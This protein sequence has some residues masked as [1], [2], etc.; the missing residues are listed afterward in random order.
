MPL[1]R[2]AFF[3]GQTT[4][5]L[6]SYIEPAN[7]P[8]AT[9]K[10]H[11]PAEEGS[12]TNVRGWHCK[13]YRFEL[14]PQCEPILMNK[15][16]LSL[17]LITAALSTTSHAEGLYGSIKILS[18]QQDLSDALLTSPRVNNR[19]VSPTSSKDVGGSVAVGYGF[20]GNWRL[21]TEYSL[22]QNSEFKSHWAPFDANVNNMQVSSSRLMINGY[23]NFPLNQHFSLYAMA[24]LGVAFIDSEGYQSNPSRRFANNSQNNFAYT[25]GVGADIKLSQQLTLGTG[26]RY[27]DMGDIETGYNTFANRINARDEQLKGK[28]REQ[29]LYVEARMAF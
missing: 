12:D 25:L 17:L 28:L 23:K 13:L 22:K 18:V 16:C 29:N 5:E 27:V 6:L 20:E 2:A 8:A 10:V 14:Y 1:D 26:Y 4:A 11:L 24:G 15:P 7:N 9:M 3:Y 19:V 21:E